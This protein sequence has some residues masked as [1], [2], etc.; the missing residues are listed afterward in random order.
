LPA[1]SKRR[2]KLPGRVLD[3]HEYIASAMQLGNPSHA[4]HSLPSVISRSFPLPEPLERLAGG[5]GCTYRAGNYV[6]R[7]EARPAEATYVAELFAQLP[8]IGFRIPR[9]IASFQGSWLSPEGWS[10]WSFVPGHH[11]AADD[12]PAALDAIHALNQV[13]AS[14]PYPPFLATKDTSF[15]RAEQGA[16]GTLPDDLDA[17]LD[18]YVRPLIAR[19]QP[20][21]DMPSQLIHID[22]NDTNILIAPDMLPA[23][24]DFTPGWRPA[25]YATA[26]FA[27][28]VGIYRGAPGVLEQCATDP[29]FDQLVLRVALSKLL[30]IHEF[31]KQDGRLIEATP[32]AAPIQRMLAWLDRATAC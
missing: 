15:T 28:W 23:F 20:L 13:L 1:H 24:V 26:V 31:Q 8:A 29:V 6:Y 10:A 30:T 12:V 7:W 18:V 3:D 32:F 9:P 25:A 19:R 11:A 17:A 2:I 21:P 5:E 4:E 16:W 14:V 22:V 27:Y